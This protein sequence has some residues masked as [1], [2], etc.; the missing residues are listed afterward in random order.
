MIVHGA[1]LTHA[2]IAPFSYNFI[3][4]LF[5]I[6]GTI[7]GPGPVGSIDRA[8]GPGPCSSKLN[9]LCDVLLACSGGDVSYIHLSGAGYFLTS[10]NSALSCA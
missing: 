1:L 7:P 3:I 4:I 2:A 10:G 5:I 9:F 8:M 6:N